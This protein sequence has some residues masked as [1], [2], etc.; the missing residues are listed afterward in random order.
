MWASCL[1]LYLPRY[2]WQQ[3]MSDYHLG[4]RASFLSRR[5]GVASFMLYLPFCL[6]SARP[7]QVG[8]S[9]HCC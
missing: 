3:Q 8:N 4:P 9:Q 7:K 6:L 5:Q 1:W 2:E